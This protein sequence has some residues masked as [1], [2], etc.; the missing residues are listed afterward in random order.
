MRVVNEGVFDSPGIN[1]G[2]RVGFAYDVFGDGKTSL[3][4]GVGVFYDRFNDDQVLQL[5]EAPPNVITATA[6][7]TT[8]KNLLATPL[9]VSPPGVFAIQT[10]LRFAGGLQLQPRRPARHRLQHGRSM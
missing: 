1:I 9:S 10:R 2:P 4:G 3:R 5:V 7:F 6:N 8:I